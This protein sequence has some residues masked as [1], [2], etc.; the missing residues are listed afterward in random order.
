MQDF[1]RIIVPI[2]QQNSYELP[3]RSIHELMQQHPTWTA[4]EQA[5]E[6]IYIVK[7]SST[8]NWKGFK[9]CVETLDKGLKILDVFWT[10]KVDSEGYLQETKPSSYRTKWTCFC[11]PWMFEEC[12]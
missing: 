3:S 5:I 8:T 12:V 2:L 4:F 1:R 9:D 7:D 6:T 10:S 11:V